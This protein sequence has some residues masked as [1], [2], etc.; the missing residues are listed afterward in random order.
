MLYRIGKIL[1]T[2][3]LNCFFELEI[4]GSDLLPKNDPFILASNHLSY[5]DP[6]VL[7]VVAPPALNYLAKEELFRNKFFGG[8]IKNVGA[9]PLERGKADIKAMRAV[10]NVLK[11]KPVVIF[12]QGARSADFDKFK[13]GVGFLY[14]RS[15]A[16]IIVA[17]IRGTDKFL[18]KG[19]R[20]ARRGKI[21]VVFD[22]VEGISRK[23]AYEDIARK[24]IGRIRS[25]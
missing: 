7:G 8:L 15:G 16:P 11:K 23:D 25:L 13:V 12:P 10:L 9:I 18:L 24:V 6:I 22:R 3:I 17:K 14:R 20:F 19:S 5:L 21:R 2:V 1:C 4:R